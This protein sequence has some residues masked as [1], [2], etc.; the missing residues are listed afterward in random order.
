MK[1]VEVVSSNFNKPV[2]VTALITGK[3]DGQYSVPGELSFSCAPGC[4]KYKSCPVT[5][6]QTISGAMALKFV[7]LNEFYFRRT[8]QSIVNPLCSK[9]VYSITKNQSIIRILV[10]EDAKTYSCYLVGNDVEINRHYELT[11]TVVADPRTQSTTCMFTSAKLV[12]S[13]I[14][15]FSVSK[16]QH[17]RL[18]A[19]KR[20]AVTADIL[21]YLV[22]YYESIATNVTHI[23]DRYDLHLA[24]DLA[25]HSPLSFVFDGEYIHKGWIES[26]VIGDTGC[27]KNCTV[28]GLLNYYGVGEIVSA[29]NTTL[30]GLVGG[31]NR[32]HDN[33]TVKWGAIPRN[34][35]GL[36]VVDEA[37][38]ILPSNWNRLDSIRSSGKAEIHRIQSYTTDART[39]IIW[40]MNANNKFISQFTHG[41]ES[42]M[43][44]MKAPQ[45]VRRFDYVIVVS[46]DEADIDTI[47]EARKPLPEFYS[48]ELE[49]ELI[50]WIWSRKK[51]E[52]IFS[53][54]AV[55]HCY[56]LSLDL[57][58]SYSD[59]IPLIQG[60]NVRH[61]LAKIAA[62][63]AGRVYSNKQSGKYLFVDKAHIECAWVFLNMIYKKPASSYLQFSRI[64]KSFDT[65]KVGTV[66]I[67]SYFDKFYTKRL[68]VLQA[69][70]MSPTITMSDISAQAT[71]SSDVAYEI[72]SKLVRYKLIERRGFSYVKTDN[73]G[74]FLRD[75][76]M[77]SLDDGGKKN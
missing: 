39:R 44:V 6:K 18:N 37:T 9:F 14:E 76:V 26:A 36:L 27:G 66:A 43:G 11:G 56:M 10:T 19:F 22:D 52:I 67:K 30:T 24:C 53:D 20:P 61:K 75:E 28:E 51:N 70:L 60:E 29:D 63:F 65:S 31:L 77:S 32:V 17:S 35:G 71:I 33:W 5:R 8:I 74:K 55:E 13:S 15:S 40:I 46:R 59:E 4:K 68:A 49:Q 45:N 69:L 38:K 1:L 16:E 25:F 23:Y 57:D 64:K 21:K 72:I 41:I 34:D 12:P 54:A 50:R 73:F 2:T 47:H 42:I 48:R 3:S 7:D 62:A 58:N